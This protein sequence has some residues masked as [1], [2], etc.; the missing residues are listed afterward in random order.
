MK[1]PL[2]FLSALLLAFSF[3]SLSADPAVSPRFGFRIDLPPGYLPTNSGLPASSGLATNSGLPANSGNNQFFFRNPQGSSFEISVI[4]QTQNPQTYLQGVVSNLGGTAEP[5]AGPPVEAF[6]YHGHKAALAEFESSAY[7]GW[8]LCISLDEGTLLALAY[9]QTKDAAQDLLHRSCLD[10]IAPSPAEQR[11]WGPITEY[12]WPRGPVGETKL[13]NTD[14]TAKIAQGDAKAAQGLIDRE[15]QVLSQFERTPQWQEAWQ[16]FYRM[17]YRD[18][19]ERIADAAFQLERSWNAALLIHDRGDSNTTTYF[20]G[21]SETALAAK[22]LSYVQEFQYERDLMGSDF[23][24]LVTA[25]TEGRGDCDSRA[26]LWAVMLNQANS[27]AGIMVSRDYGH[28]MGI[29]DL[30]GE[31]ARFPFAGN[32]YLVA[33]TTA[34]VNLGLIGQNVSEISKWLGVLFE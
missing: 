34:K 5:K 29:A 33:E 2:F 27:D 15:F 7:K 16:R 23:I 25:L 8:G 24:N 26:L 1:A 11:Y 4:S 30:A 9:G 31:G 21:L 3:S 6:E 13:F 20:S 32:Q 18:S 10:S 19:Y 14:I 12:T 22:A 28:A 17:I